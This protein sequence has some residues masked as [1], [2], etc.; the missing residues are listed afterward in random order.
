MTF[1]KT[2]DVVANQNIDYTSK[3]KNQ[4]ITKH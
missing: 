3:T 1:F 4:N 2:Q